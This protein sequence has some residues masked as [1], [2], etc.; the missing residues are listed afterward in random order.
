MT[1]AHSNKFSESYYR[2]QARLALANNALLSF[3]AGA[4]TMF[5]VCIFSHTFTFT[6]QPNEVKS[7]HDHGR[8]SYEM[9]QSC[10]NT[11]LV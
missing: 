2:G 1:G 5:T 10:P 7:N 4:A 3:F 11:L 6:S 8:L 9:I